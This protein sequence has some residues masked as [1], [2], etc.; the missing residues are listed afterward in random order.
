MEQLVRMEHISKHFGPIRALENVD[1]AV[2]PGEVVGLVG[3]NGA[4]KSTLINIL[5]G[6]FPPSKGNIYFDGKRIPFLTSRKSRRL[7]IQTV[8]Q[9]FGLID[10]LPID[11]NLVLGQEPT[12]RFLFL[13]FLDRK[14]M[15]DMTK[16]MLATIDIKRKLQ[17]TFLVGQLSGG[18]K[19]SVKLG[20]SISY[21]DRLLILDEPVTGL[22][23]RESENVM[24]MIAR[25]KAANVAVI[26]ISHDV[27]Q[28]YSIADRIVVLDRGIKLLD[29]PKQEKT[30]QQIINMIRN[31]DEAHRAVAGLED[32]CGYASQPNA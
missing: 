13:R 20:R 17:P 30:P 8:H 16:E 29:L 32:E 15:T 25:I 27:F 1:F 18:E 11:R 14:K 21:E 9:G 28:V 5:S 2:Y 24:K 23:V 6:I 3:D 12:R 26:F 7:G 31:P 19:Q 22:S 4:G 10:L